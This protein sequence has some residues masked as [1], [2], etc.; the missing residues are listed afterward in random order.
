MLLLD[1]ASYLT[2]VMAVIDRL[3]V[4]AQLQVRLTRDKH[5]THAK[6]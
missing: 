4:K 3:P 5:G 6:Y 1:E 2:D